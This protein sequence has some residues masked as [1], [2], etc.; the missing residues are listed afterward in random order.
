MLNEAS[1]FFFAFNHFGDDGVGNVDVS[2]LDYPF[3]DGTMSKDT[4]LRVHL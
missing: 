2:C 1:M 4:L 3:I